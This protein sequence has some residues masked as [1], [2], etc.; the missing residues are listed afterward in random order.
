[1]VSESAVRNFRTN[2]NGASVAAR[3][4]RPAGMLRPDVSVHYL[5]IWWWFGLDRSSTI[6]ILSWCTQGLYIIGLAIPHLS[7][8]VATTAAQ[9]GPGSNRSVTACETVQRVM[10]AIG[11]F[12]LGVVGLGLFFAWSAI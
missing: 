4:A 9:F 10:S 2:C 1:M 6:I 7:F 11:H 8:M 12:L 5:P 3:R